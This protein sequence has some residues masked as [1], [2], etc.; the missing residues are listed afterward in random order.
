M[1]FR[2]VRVD[3]NLVKALLSIKGAFI[4]KS[5]MY[6][7]F[8]GGVL[9]GDKPIRFTPEDAERYYDFVFQ[10]SEHELEQAVRSVKIPDEQGRMI[11]S[12]DPEFNIAG[13]PFNIACIWLIHKIQKSDLDPAQKLQAR[14]AV[15]FYLMCSFLTS[16]MRNRSEEHTS[17]L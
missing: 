16:I 11:H 2:S 3:R 15:M 5:A 8:F 14:S 12:I 17:E 9:T 6:V 7:D 10:T 13:K 1:L 4:T